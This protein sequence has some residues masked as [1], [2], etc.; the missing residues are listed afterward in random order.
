MAVAVAYPFYFMVTSSFKDLLD[1]TRNPPDVFPA[2]LHPENYVEAWNR[3]P[4][5]RYFLNTIF[6][7]LVVTL[8][9]IVTAALAFILTLII[10]LFTLVQFRLVGRRVYY[11]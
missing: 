5:G 9:E 1:A 7:S 3:A 10:L 11:D 4:W 2:V 6:V 8:G